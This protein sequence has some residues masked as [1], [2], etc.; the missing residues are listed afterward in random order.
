MTEIDSLRRELLK[1]GLSASSVALLLSTGLTY[2]TQLLAHWPEDAFTARAVEDALLAIMGEAEVS[3]EV[4]VHFKKGQPAKKNSSGD[5]VSIEVDTDLEQIDR[6]AIL[7]D[8]NPFPLVMS[9]EMF[10]AVKFPIKTRIK[11]AGAGHVMAVVRS[12]EQLYMTKQA[13]KVD[14]GGV[15]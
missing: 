1:K 6:L 7:V 2:P 4:K 3:S 15:V 14:V 8:S 12:G 9:M 13:V 5:S 10:S 11:I